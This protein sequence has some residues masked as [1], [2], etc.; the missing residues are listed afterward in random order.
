[1]KIFSTVLLL[2]A[3]AATLV[4]APSASARNRGPIAPVARKADTLK[5]VAAAPAAERPTEVR[6]IYYTGNVAITDS[7][8]A[9]PIALGMLIDSTDVV[10]IGRGATMQLAVDGRVVTLQR[11]S[12]VTRAEIIRRAVGEPNEELMAALRALAAH[13][14]FMAN[15]AVSPA[16]V[17]AALAAAITPTARAASPSHTRMLVPLEP[18][19]TSVV[20]GPL[21][22]RWLRS[23]PNATYRVVVRDRYD[24]E[25]FRAE[26]SDTI[27]TWESAVL[28]VGSDYTWS[29]TRVDDSVTAITST[30]R[31]LDD[32]QGMRLEGGESR[33]RLA[34]GSENPALPVILGA[35]FALHGCYAEAVRQYTTAA[36]RTPEHFDRF[37]RLAREQY[38][39]NIGLS[40][41]ELEHVQTLGAMTMN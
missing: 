9:L 37:L 17:Q 27:V 6:V 33:I 41:T 8:T 4:P 40:P 39:L 22:F 14:S 28:F 10:R 1:M 36:L 5:E 30:F 24:A 13:G 15:T 32:I 35:H 12:S 18:R 26:T 7:T 38:A 21:H 34:L 16:R 11:P 2:V 23:D 29:L 25:V 31:R 19:N 20:R 3:I